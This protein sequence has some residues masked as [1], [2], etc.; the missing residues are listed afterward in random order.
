[1]KKVVVIG[2]GFAGS[3]TAKNLEKD[4]EVTL[5]DTKDYFEYKPSVLTLLRNPQRVDEIRVKHRNHLKK[6]LA[7]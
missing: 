7:F 5:V 1:M 4:F 6:L 3:Y 2:G